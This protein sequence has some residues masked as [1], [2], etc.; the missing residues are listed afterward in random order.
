MAN[1]SVAKKAP[2]AK[3]RK[4]SPEAQKLLPYPDFPLSPHL[5][6]GRWY[7]VINGTR[8]Y[9]GPLDDPDAALEK[10]QREKDDLYAGRKPRESAEGYTVRQLVNEYLT[11]QHRKL[12]AGELRPRTFN[13]YHRTGTLI[14]DAFGR[15]RRVDDLAADDFE[16]LRAQLAETH[17]PVRLGIAIQQVR[18][19]FKWAWDNGKIDKPIRYGQAFN[20]P[21]ARVMREQRNAR[22]V[23]MFTA[24]EIKALLDKAS[25]PMKAMILLGVNCGLGNTDVA[26]LPLSAVDLDAGTLDFPRPKTGVARRAPL[27]PET[28][29]AIRAALEKRPEPE[30]E[31]DAPRLFITKHGAAWV[32]YHT[33][34]D[35]DKPKGCAV[36]NVSREFQKIK[37]VAGVNGERRG[38]YA[39][40]HTFETIGGE[41][42][43]QKAVDFIMGH[44]PHATDMSAVYREWTGDSRE[45]ARLKRVTDH[46][47][48]WLY[49]PKATKKTAAKKK[50]SKKRAAAKGSK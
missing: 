3:R 9:F 34:G 22:P 7:K 27:W 5:P 11:A 47:R 2:D 23:R 12:K 29:K 15:N 42:G 26:D 21:S 18:Q 35:P 31:A 13:E 30:D 37:T 20:K 1:R 14:A 49:P 38:F 8:H 36:D 10:Y 39:L 25:V 28:V 50:A 6:T 44:A 43:D 4:L 24:D 45:H 41:T 17:S 16:P 33:N 48:S 32:R 40:R 46:V 19:V